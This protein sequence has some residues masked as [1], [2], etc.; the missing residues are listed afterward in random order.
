MKLLNNIEVIEWHNTRLL[1]FYSYLAVQVF[2]NGQYSEKASP[3]FIF[4][5]FFDLH[6]SVN[7]RFL[8]KFF[9]TQA[10]EK[11]CTRL[12]L[13][14]IHPEDVFICFQHILVQIL[15]FGVFQKWNFKSGTEKTFS[16]SKN[17]HYNIFKS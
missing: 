7:N 4:C 9:L 13:P 3:V 16:S 11:Y 8:Y 12:K 17:Y 2:C 5:V 14:F 10:E 15:G 1:A 6:Q